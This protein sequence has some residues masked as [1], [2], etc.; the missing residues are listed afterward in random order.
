MIKKWKINSTKEILRGRIFKYV[1]CSVTCEEE[2]F[3]MEMDTL[4]FADWVNIVA[5]TPD[6]QVVMVKQYRIGTDDLTVE[7]PG[8]AVDKGEAPLAA[9][10]REL[11]E[12]TGYQSDEW[13]ELGWVHPNPAFMNNKCF[14]YLAKNAVP[15]GTQSLDPFEVL[16]I[17]HYPLSEVPQMIKDETISHSLVISSFHFYYS[18]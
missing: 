12:E 4:K 8:G 3:D 17:E 6:Q 14:M 1:S 15:S 16:D 13:E 7:T 10:K 11:E 18:K 5:I 9:A 2:N